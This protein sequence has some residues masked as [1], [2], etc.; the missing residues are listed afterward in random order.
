MDG[1]ELPQ[2]DGESISSWHRR[3]AALVR[4]QQISAYG[5]GFDID[6]GNCASCWFGESMIAHIRIVTEQGKISGHICEKCALRIIDQLERVIEK[7][8][9]RLERDRVTRSPERQKGHDDEESSK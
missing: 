9:K 3:R 5:Y 2:N 7:R 1:R 8:L 4:K 6:S